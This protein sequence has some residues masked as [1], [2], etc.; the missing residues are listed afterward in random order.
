LG[1]ALGGIDTLVK[2]IV[3]SLAQQPHLQLGVV[4]RIFNE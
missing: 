1:K 2:D 3:A 4:F